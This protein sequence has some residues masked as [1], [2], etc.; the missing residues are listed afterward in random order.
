MSQDEPIFSINN[1][2]ALAQEVSAIVS[3]SLRPTVPSSV[4]LITLLARC[5]VIVPPIFLCP[6]RT[7]AN[8]DSCCQELYA[9]APDPV[10]FWDPLDE[11]EQVA[12]GGS[13][14]G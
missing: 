8:T 4:G 2:L 10:P 7:G 14:A 3:I 1:Q 5:P 9:P 6:H 13:M 11:V 12:A